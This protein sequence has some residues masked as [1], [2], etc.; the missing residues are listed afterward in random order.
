MAERLHAVHFTALSSGM[1][2]RHAHPDLTALTTHALQHDV[3]NASVMPA[4]LRQQQSQRQ[5]QPQGLQAPAAAHSSALRDGA[6][7]AATLLAEPLTE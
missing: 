1:R 6:L 2:Q 5:Q 4:P 7:V 3:V